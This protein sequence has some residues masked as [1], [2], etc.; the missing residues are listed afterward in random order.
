[1]VE[2]FEIKEINVGNLEILKAFIDNA[3]NTVESFRYFN[4]RPLKIISNHIITV[5]ILDDKVPVGYGHLDKE[6]DKIWFGIAISEKYKGKGLGKKIMQYLMGYADRNKISDIFL[7]VD[8]TN[9][10]AIK[11]YQKFNFL[12]VKDLSS[13]V[14]LMKRKCSYEI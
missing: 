10:V 1:M 11:M 9:I 12:E 6:E 2:S 14:L 3:G 5:V 4:T 8:K 7:S 13:S